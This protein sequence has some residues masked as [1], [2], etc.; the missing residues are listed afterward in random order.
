[1]E[2]PLVKKLRTQRGLKILN[3]IL[4]AAAQVFYEKGYSAANV[5]DIA[6]LADVATGT[7]YIYFDGKYELYK[8]LLL[9]LCLQHHLRI[10]VCGRRILFRHDGILEHFLHSK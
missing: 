7:F 10:F 3:K 2:H 5:N 4:S 9:Q 6:T 1:M 8:F